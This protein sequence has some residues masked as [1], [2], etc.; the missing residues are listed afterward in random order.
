MGCLQ[1]GSLASSPRQLVGNLDEVTDV[2]LLSCA[3]DASAAT[4]LL[5][6][7]WACQQVPH[8][9]GLLPTM[10]TLHALAAVAQRLHDL[11]Q[12]CPLPSRAWSTSS[13]QSTWTSLD[14]QEG[15][16]SAGTSIIPHVHTDT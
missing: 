4:P 12:P 15:G 10:L 3:S 11:C 6:V 5:E 9:H 7:S 1:D 13:K 8:K 16:A 14:Q 2:R